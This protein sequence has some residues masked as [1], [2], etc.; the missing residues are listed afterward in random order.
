ME[1]LNSKQR[2][3]LIDLKNRLMEESHIAY[4]FAAIERDDI[5]EFVLLEESRVKEKISKELNSIIYETT[6]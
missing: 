5:K 1:T 4:Q 2:Q 3:Q 6:T